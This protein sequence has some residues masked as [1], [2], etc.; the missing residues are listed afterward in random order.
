M[1]IASTH[2]KWMNRINIVF[3]HFDRQTLSVRSWHMFT[4]NI[5]HIREGSH[6]SKAKLAHKLASHM[7]AV[8]LMDRLGHFINAPFCNFGIDP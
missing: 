3:D 4:Y 6:L 1:L 5:A 2:L 7:I 8:S